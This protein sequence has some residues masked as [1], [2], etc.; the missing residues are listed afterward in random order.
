MC[1]LNGSMVLQ[2]IHMS[3]PSERDVIQLASAL[4]APFRPQIEGGLPTYFCFSGDRLAQSMSAAGIPFEDPMDYLNEC[5]STLLQIE[6]RGVRLRSHVAQTTVG[7]PSLVIVLV[8]QQVLAVERMYRDDEGFSEHAYF[9]RLRAMISPILVNMP[10]N[11]FESEE[12]DFIWRTLANDVRL[13]PGSREDSVTFRFGIEHGVNKARSFPFSQ[14]LLSQHD[15]IAIVTKVGA[16]RILEST[17]ENLWSEVTRFRDELG[18][19]AQRLLFVGPLRDRL[20]AQIRHFASLNKPTLLLKPFPDDERNPKWRLRAFKESIDW[21]TEEI[22]LILYDPETG[23]RNYDRFALEEEVGGRLRRQDVIVL[24]ESELGD[25]WELKVGQ[26]QVHPGESIILVGSKAHVEQILGRGRT[27]ECNIDWEL[28]C[29][30]ADVVANGTLAAEVTWLARNADTLV[31]RNGA[32]VVDSAIGRPAEYTW[33]GGIRVSARGDKYL[34]SALPFGI[35]FAEDEFPITA[36]QQIDDHFLSFDDFN[37][38]VENL[39]EDADFEFKFSGGRKARLSVAIRRRIGSMIVGYPLGALGRLSAT[40]RRIALGDS[41]LIG[42]REVGLAHARMISVSL[43]A[44]VLSDLR[45]GT[46][47]KLDPAITSLICSRLQFASLPIE[48]RSAISWLVQQDSSR[49][50][51]AVVSELRNVARTSSSATAIGAELL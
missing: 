45:H 47:D 27:G 28:V 38:G 29:E 25:C 37:S 44:R 36:F 9:P 35:R 34:W 6:R 18:R 31:W 42:L 23:A 32:F 5:A 15:L 48:V 33:L 19:R 51:S 43:W 24:S 7:S 10:S 46:G 22:R 30:T 2:S 21:M 3:S 39:T 4:W 8:C 11:P 12:F 40:A 50:S 14:A 26:T 41:A 20:L 13:I 16:Q 49:V 1:V 17:S